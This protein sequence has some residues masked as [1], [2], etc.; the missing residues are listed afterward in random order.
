MGN[1]PWIAH[2]LR[3]QKL[4]ERRRGGGRDRWANIVE[5]RS[6]LVYASLS[7][8]AGR[9]YRDIWEETLNLTSHFK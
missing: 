2:L 8:L 7:G 6:H 5:G 1:R 3:V 4:E 9:D